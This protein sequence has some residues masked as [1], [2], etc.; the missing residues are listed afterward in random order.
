[1]GAEISIPAWA[2]LL[3]WAVGGLLIG[4]RWINAKSAHMVLVRPAVGERLQ[5][6]IGI[7]AAGPIVWGAVGWAFIADA[8]AALR[9]K[10]ANRGATH[11]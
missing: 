5:L 11:Q 4:S 1:M 7:A 6:A 9:R 8:V 10:L 2:L 3:C